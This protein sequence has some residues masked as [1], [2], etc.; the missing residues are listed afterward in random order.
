ML[1]EEEDRPTVCH[2]LLVLVC[3]GFFLWPLNIRFSLWVT[4][5][6]CF[7]SNIYAQKFRFDVLGAALGGQDYRNVY[8]VASG[9]MKIALSASPHFL[10][11]LGDSFYWC[12]IQNTSDYQINVD[13]IKPYNSLE[14]PFYGVLG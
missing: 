4:G 12:G 9:M 5:V 14:L 6:V 7:L 13:Y 10:L 11:N 3:F 2:L 1:K 8:D